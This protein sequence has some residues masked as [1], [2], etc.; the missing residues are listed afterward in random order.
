MQ[1]PN[2]NYIEEELARVRKMSGS[3]SSIFTS[4]TITHNNFGE[5]TFSLAEIIA[6]A[7]AIIK[8]KLTEVDQA[9]APLS[10]T[11]QKGNSFELSSIED[12]L[13]AV[14]RFEL[15]DDAEPYYFNIG[16][17]E[18]DIERR[19]RKASDSRD[20]SGERTTGSFLRE[21]S[22]IAYTI[23]MNFSEAETLQQLREFFGDVRA[24][25]LLVQLGPL[26]LSLVKQLD[27]RASD[28]RN[29]VGSD[30]R[31][32]IEDLGNG[33]IY[34]ELSRRHD[35]TVVATG[36]LGQIRQQLPQLLVD[37]LAD[38]R[39][40]VRDPQSGLVGVYRFFNIDAANV[41]AVLLNCW[42]VIQGIA[43]NSPEFRNLFANDFTTFI[44]QIFDRMA[45]VE[46]DVS[47]QEFVRFINK[48]VMKEI[49]RVLYNRALRA[50][51]YL[52]VTMGAWFVSE[53]ARYPASF[54]GGLM[55][56][57]LIEGEHLSPDK[58][59]QYSFSNALKYSG[60]DCH[61]IDA[62]GVLYRAEC[63]DSERCQ[64]CCDFNANKKAF[65]ERLAPL[66]KTELENLAGQYFEV[67]SV[68]KKDDLI[69]KL[70]NVVYPKASANKL[71]AGYHPMV[72][73]NSFIEQKNR[74][75]GRAAISHQKLGSLVMQWL[76]LQLRAVKGLT[77]TLNQS[78]VV[79]GVDNDIGARSLRI[80]KELITNILNSLLI[81]RLHDFGFMDH[82]N[83]RV[84]GI[85]RGLE[86]TLL[87]PLRRRSATFFQWRT[88]PPTPE[89]IEQKAV[90]KQA[91]R[92]SI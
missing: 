20:N 48:Q 90:V 79:K 54:L 12:W 14:A 24:D 3:S 89:P 9:S 36:E 52:P 82:K 57:D 75:A 29:R 34:S 5:L 72:H 40:D 65:K 87:K 13:L 56:L 11:R 49:R 22:D 28:T 68:I 2:E 86:A 27:A 69:N 60:T 76:T 31:S 38:L 84:Q 6:L 67:P 73:G 18:I 1:G 63:D 47:Q 42:R 30:S 44:T 41:D 39:R 7:E 26:Y 85:L 66:N 19:Q 25:D 80:K 62:Y 4:V 17:T 74:F 21:I 53:A 33:P 64:A 8:E 16:G 71:V 78:C 59:Q 23:F 51:N 88:E 81:A 37:M 77:V 92:K 70:A 91:R 50:H 83:Y 45:S 10:G 55:L 43:R 35:S 15:D 46:N 32:R 61:F 58:T